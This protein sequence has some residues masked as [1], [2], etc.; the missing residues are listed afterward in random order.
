MSDQKNDQKGKPSAG[1]Q[2]VG[3][4]VRGFIKQ[5]NA[6]VSSLLHTGRGVKKVSRDEIELAVTVVM[7]DIANS[8]QN[9]CT[10]EYVMIQN[11]LRRLFGTDKTKVPKLVQEAKQIIANMRGATSFRETLR[12]G[13]DIQQKLAVVECINELIDADG[14]QDGFEIY[15]KQR[16]RAALG[17]PDDDAATPPVDSSGKK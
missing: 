3:N 9:F 13:L 16:L 6:S 1:N 7:V 10:N 15:L 11:G 8:D 4:T 5:H 17:L 14:A 12:D 2:L